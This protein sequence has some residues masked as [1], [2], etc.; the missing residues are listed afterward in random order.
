MRS[1][2]APP[3]TRGFRGGCGFGTQ[4]RKCCRKGRC[5]GPL[6][7]GRL[8]PGFRFIYRYLERFRGAAPSHFD[9]PL[10]EPPATNRNPRRN[11]EEPRV[12]YLP[13]A[14]FV[15]AARAPAAPPPPP[16]GEKPARDQ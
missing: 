13:P 6:P 11:P 15:P 2:L 5:S 10:P 16:G 14:P 1:P 7:D 12:L 4:A 8:N 3:W 9:D